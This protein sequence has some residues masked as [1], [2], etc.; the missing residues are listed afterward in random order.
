[1]QF[2][3]MAERPPT[4]EQQ[5]LIRKDIAK[6]NEENRRIN[7]KLNKRLNNFVVKRFSVFPP[8]MQMLL[9]S[10]YFKDN[11]IYREIKF[12]ELIISLEVDEAFVDFIK[13]TEYMGI[14]KFNQMANLARRVLGFDMKYSKYT[15]AGLKA[16]L[17]NAMK[18]DGVDVYEV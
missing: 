8:M 7:G 4:P 3:F 16:M 18:E 9:L 17:I 13:S 12:N 5:E 14:T 10:D 1:M 6:T 11:D 2:K 15:I